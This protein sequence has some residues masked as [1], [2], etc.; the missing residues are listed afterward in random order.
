[1]TFVK[2]KLGDETVWV[3]ES[4]LEPGGQGG[5]ALGSQVAD[6]ELSFPECFIDAPYAY[7]YEN[8]SIYRFGVKI[9]RREDLQPDPL[10]DEGEGG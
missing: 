2:M 8:G 10:A 5:L 1:M 9:G 7:C 3:Q 4:T 6:G